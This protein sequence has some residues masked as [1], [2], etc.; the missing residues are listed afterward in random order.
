ML[1]GSLSGIELISH[2]VTGIDKCRACCH[3]PAICDGSQLSLPSQFMIE[4][5]FW[6][7]VMRLLQFDPP[8]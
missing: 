2:G 3:S 8:R 4:F 7:F 6:N 1:K 5:L